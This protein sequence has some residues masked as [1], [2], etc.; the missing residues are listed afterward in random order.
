VVDPADS[1]AA[2][3]GQARELQL[4]RACIRDLAAL[5]ALPGLL[6][7]HDFAGIAASV[8]DVVFSIL[9]LTVAYI[10][11]DAGADGAPLERVLPPGCAPESLGKALEARLTPDEAAAEVRSVENPLGAGAVRTARAFLGV[12][13]RDGVLIVGA[14]RDDFP[15]DVEKF[16]LQSAANQATIALQTARLLAERRASEAR[17]ARE[18][19]ATQR[20]QEVSGRL[21][22]EGDVDAL[23]RKIVDD[24]RAIVQ[25]DMASM[26][27]LDEARDAL[28]LLAWRGFGEE[29]GW[30]FALSGPDAPTACSLAWRL[31]R[32]VVVPDVEAW[33]VAAGT[34]ALDGFRRAGIRAVQS[35]PLISRSGKLV[36]M[37]STHWRQPHQPAEPDLRLLDVLA[38]QAADLLERVDAERALRAS[39][40]RFRTVV[41]QASTGVVQT[42]VTGR[43]TLVNQR[44]CE[45]VGY[46]EAELLAMNVADVIDPD[47]RAPALEAFRRLA[48][49]GPSFVIDGRYR[50]RDGSQ[51]WASCS[52]SALRG[53]AGEYLGAVAVVVDVTE[54]KSA[55]EA[56]RSADRAKDEFL[57][58]LGHELRNPLGALASA[59]QLLDV[60]DRSSA[61]AARAR[62]VIGRQLD[63]LTRLVD[64]LLDVTRLTAAKIRLTPRLLDLA[65]AVKG[66][67]DALA[68]RGTLDRHQVT[69]EGQTVWIDADETR[70]EQIVANLVGNAV[71][72]TPPGGTIA[73]TVGRDGAHGVLAVRDTGVGIAAGILPRI[74]DLFVQGERTLDRSQGGLG[75]G[76]T[77]VRR[78]VELH[79]GTV[80]AAS[81]GVGMGSVFT[82]RLPA[83]AP[84][85]SSASPP[86]VETA[87]PPRRLLIVEDND[88]AREMLRTVLAHNG[89]E[90]HEAADGPSGLE[91]MLALRP[92][93]ALVDVGLPGL[94]GYEVARRVRARPEGRDIFLIALTGYGQPEDRRRAEDAG[95]DDHVVKPVDPDWLVSLLARVR[96]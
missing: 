71:K 4:L 87:R 50:R 6:S 44:W 23:Y 93:I 37:I 30:S 49:G 36:G 66:A 51:L 39:E 73:V 18:L 54:R 56:L 83:V 21:I 95:F 5:S 80:Q 96:R 1:R 57:A 10:R 15:T 48:E 62:A 13:G 47:D 19:A 12:G 29:F 81:G 89:H 88:D 72:F 75:I 55:E 16:L 42:D 82:V 90:V 38:R 52:V 94:D 59:A 53:G 68:A 91:A 25:S 31:R 34:P 86:A 3:E 40:A 46:T 61:V 84:P 70:L 64:D 26:Q 69:F 14:A 7:G 58:M 41:D 60:E 78:L 33:D 92:E 32:R 20:L 11:V 79:G 9:R 28:R 65:Q 43:M 22:E 17:L 35:T 8:L 63:H 45:M 85:A 27:V 77:L 67:V 76:L 2:G 74:F 24:A